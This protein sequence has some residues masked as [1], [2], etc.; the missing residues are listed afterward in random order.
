MTITI[1]DT[2]TATTTT[3]DGVVGC[4]GVGVFYVTR[5]SN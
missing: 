2:T 1:T 5:V 4:G 3:T